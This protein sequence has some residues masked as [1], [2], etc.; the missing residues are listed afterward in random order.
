[1]G[2]PEK[3]ERVPKPYSDLSSNGL[4]AWDAKGLRE[5]TDL[6]VYRGGE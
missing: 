4:N 3:G 6:R 1:M 5:T 2:L